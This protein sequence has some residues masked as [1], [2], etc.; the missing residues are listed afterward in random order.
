MDLHAAVSERR[1]DRAVTIASQIER[2][3]DLLV[4]VL[5]VPTQHESEIDLREPARPLLL[6]LALDLDRQRLQRLLELPQQEDGV[7][8]GAAAEGAEQHLGGSHRLV[9]AEDA[10]LVDAGG[11][12]RS[13]LD[14]ELH[15][16]SAPPRAD[17][18][19]GP[20]DSPT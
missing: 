9:V 6:L 1:V 15:L 16:A 3:L 5:A 14:I 18:R 17:L 10:G 4:V 20:N 2:L 12:A 8:A 7:D 19:H 11:V 13:R